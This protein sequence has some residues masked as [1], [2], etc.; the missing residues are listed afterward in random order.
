MSLEE[1]FHIEN[2]V[3][4]LDVNDKNDNSEKNKIKAHCEVEENGS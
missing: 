3:D 2:N 1:F 4:D